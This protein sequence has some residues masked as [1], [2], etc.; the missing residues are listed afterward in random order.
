MLF[1]TGCIS[2]LT[3]SVGQTSDSPAKNV[4][5]F[6]GD[7]MGFE[8]V[9]A[10]GIYANGE[11]GTL[12]FESL[13][14][15]G[16]VSTYSANEPV[17]DSAAA[18][19]AMATGVKANNGV[20]SLKIPGDSSELK[21]ML[22]YYKEKGKAVGLV[23]TAYISHATPAGFGAHEPAR[24]NNKQIIE[25]YLSQTKPDVLLGGAK[26][27]APSQAVDAGYTVVTDRKGLLAVDTDN[28]TQLSGQ[29]GE[30]H[31]P[32]EYDGVGDMPHLS[33]MARIAIDI[34]DNDPDG[35]FLMI[36][37]GRIDHAGHKNQLE[38]N[39]LET[40]E[41]SNTVEETFDWAKQRTDTLLLVTA[42]HETGGLSVT[43]E[44]P[45]KNSFPQVEWKTGGHTSVN[46]PVYAWG[47][48]AE[49]FSGVM[50]NTDFFLM[51]T[52]PLILSTTH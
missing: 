48:N 12:S 40:I 4:I 2:E 49:Q 23:S 51:I 39:I 52:D 20:I 42:D 5:F 1:V 45:T 22:E 28:V 13:P 35:F 10:A 38:R 19:T 41:L 37:A 15:K 11:A 17:T 26:Y 47:V 21:T 6:I 9:K 36:E 31:M 16:Q 27:I 44:N 32:Y 3:N 14:Y 29:F 25:D 50:D 34:L 7:G 8:Q 30:D 24:G 18:A 33:D 43:E 46:V